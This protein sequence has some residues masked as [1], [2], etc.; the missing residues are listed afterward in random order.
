[1]KPNRR[2]LFMKKLTRERV[3]PIISARVS[4][5][6]FVRTGSGR[7]SLPKFASSKKQPRQ[8]FLARIEQLVDQILFDPDISRQ[9]VRKKHLGKRS[10]VRSTL[11]MAPFSSRAIE[12][13]V[14]AAT[15]AM[16]RFCPAKHPS[17]KTVGC[18]RHRWLSTWRPLLLWASRGR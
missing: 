11:I 5:R 18:C 3:V 17:P 9:D 16:R 15:V 12:H 14:I 6:I 2:N 4:C 8:A 7:P 1:M 13:S 10:L